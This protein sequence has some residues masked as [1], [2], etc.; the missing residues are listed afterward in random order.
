MPGLLFG[1][2]FDTL[3]CVAA[4]PRRFVD[5]VIANMKVAQWQS[6]GNTLM[7]DW[8]MMNA[9]I[10]EGAPGVNY[11]QSNLNVGFS[12]AAIYSKPLVMSRIHFHNFPAGDARVRMGACTLL[13][14]TAGAVRC[15][16]PLTAFDCL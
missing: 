3:R 10:V 5:I 13:S 11:P 16:P 9:P 1:L 15:C 2:L 4:H 6:M 14:S 12:G 8:M 7:Q